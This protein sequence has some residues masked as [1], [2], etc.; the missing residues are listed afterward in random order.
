MNNKKLGVVTL[1]AGALT[2]GVANAESTV[3]LHY[4]DYKEGDDRINVGDTTLALK[5]EL[6]VDYTLNLSLGYDSV[7][8]ASPAWQVNDTNPSDDFNHGKLLTARGKTDQT[9]LGYTNDLSRYAI[10]RVGL[11]DT[12][13]SFV[14]SLTMRD[15]FRNELTV[16]LSHSKE[17]D[18]ESNSISASY[19]VYLDKYK[20]RSINFGGAFLDD[21]TLVFSEGYLSERTEDKLRFINLEAGFTQVLSPEA[22]VDFKLFYNNDSGFL[23]NHYLTILRGVDLNNDES[24]AQDEYF[25]AADARPD[26]RQAWGVKASGAWQI[27]PWLTAQASYRFYSDDWDIASH[28]V[29]SSIAFEPSTGWF[30]TPEIVFYSQS[31]ASFYRNPNGDEKAFAATGFGSNDVRLGDYTATTYG[32]STAYQ[33]DEHWQVDFAATHYSQSNNFSATWLVAGIN[34]KF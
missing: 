26:S 23:S 15:E 21:T 2:Q 7:S 10:K 17:N 32:L 18:Y 5:L 22:T 1:A 20:N 28:T 29:K 24:I 30:I 9:L 19:L 14:S 4:L 16:G 27:K 33:L 8:G 25:L 6:G 13:K 12:R 3:S 11:V 34:Y 31:Q